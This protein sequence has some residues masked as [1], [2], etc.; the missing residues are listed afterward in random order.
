MLERGQW[1]AES[2][3][4]KVSPDDALKRIHLID[5]QRFSRVYNRYLDEKSLL[6][7]YISDPEKNGLLLI[8]VEC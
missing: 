2:S 7:I 4:Q 3:Q 1:V 5:E 8:S 6:G